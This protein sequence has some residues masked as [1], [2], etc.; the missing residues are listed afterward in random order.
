MPVVAS[1]AFPSLSLGALAGG[2][3]SLDDAWANGEALILLGH[4]NCKTT[5]QTLP[6]V[7]RLHRRKAPQATVLAVL[8][9]DAET[10]AT[11]VREQGIGLPVLLEDDPYPLAAAL[12]LETVPTLFLVERGGSIVK[13][14]EG[15]NRAEI[16]G[17]AAR[18]GVAGPLFVP[19]DNAPATKPG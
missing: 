6:F 12:R 7:D 14:V 2:E 10:A 18:L 16:E 13:A 9:D 4:R 11:L 19:E 17:F 3:R 15:F 1:G 5:R 8:Q